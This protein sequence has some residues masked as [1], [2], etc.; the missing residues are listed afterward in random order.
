MITCR[1]LVELLLD[2]V[3]GQMPQE[4]R[5]L[6]E[7]HLGRC[8]PCVAYL[9]S[10][11]TVVAVTRRLPAASLPAHLEQR[12]QALLREHSPDQTPSGGPAG[13]GR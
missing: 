7:R 11:R 4:Q 10:Y 5:D 9:E 1:E 2:F 12:L 6:I 13:P 3:S 8:P